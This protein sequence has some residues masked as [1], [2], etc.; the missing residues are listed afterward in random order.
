MRHEK[1]AAAARDEFSET[2]NRVAYGGERVVIS[3]RG[4]KLAAV[5]PIAD[6]ELLERLSLEEENRADLAAARKALKEAEQKGTK[7]L[8]AFR[9]EL[10]E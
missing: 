3:R 8:E 10:G 7:S 4:K 6:L 5:V 2:L 1:T 9:R